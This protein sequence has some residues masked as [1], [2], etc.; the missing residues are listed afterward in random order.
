[1]SLYKRLHEVT[2]R[3]AADRA[4]PGARRASAEDPPPPHRRA[5]ADP[6][7]Q[8]AVARTTCA[9]GS[10][11]SS[12]R[13]GPG[14]RPAVG[15]RQG[16]AHPGRLRRHPRLRPDR[17][18]AARTTTSPKSWCNG[19]EHGLRRARRQA[20]RSRRV[21]FVDETH[22]RRIIDKIVG[23]VGRRIDES[24]P[25][26]DARLPDGSRVNAVDPP[27]RHRR[28]VP[29]HPEVL[30]GPVPDRRPHPLRHAQ[31]RTSARFLAGLRRRPPQRHRLR[32]YRHR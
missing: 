19:P 10:T 13:P 1:M 27:A 9:A 26:V 32:R 5:R 28:P 4:R 17:P 2:R 22:L 8:A 16:P 15:R 20:S 25:M 29:H 30:Q 31:R 24:T 14:A 11:S 3:R 23:Q 7:R 21:S 18:V 6:L 12:T